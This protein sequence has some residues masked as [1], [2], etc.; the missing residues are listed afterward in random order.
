MSNLVNHL[1]VKVHVLLHCLEL[2]LLQVR[3]YLNKVF[4]ALS[5]ETETGSIVSLHLPFNLFDVVCEVWWFD[6]GHC[7]VYWR[8]LVL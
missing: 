4:L 8:L 7:L 2:Q 5:Q 6:V 3:L 1:V